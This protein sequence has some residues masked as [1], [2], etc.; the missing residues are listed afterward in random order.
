MEK[1]CTYYYHKYA[2]QKFSLFFSVDSIKRLFELYRSQY[3]YAQYYE[4]VHKWICEF[5][6]ANKFICAWENVLKQNSQGTCPKNVASIV[7]IGNKLQW[8]Q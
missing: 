8:N 5:A 4:Y 7:T 6:G 3:V 2:I 1:S